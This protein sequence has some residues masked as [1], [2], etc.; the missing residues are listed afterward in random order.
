MQKQHNP[1]HKC[2]VYIC[3]SG[4]GFVANP[5]NDVDKESFTTHGIYVKKLSV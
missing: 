5:V 2:P 3:A 1:S 4:D